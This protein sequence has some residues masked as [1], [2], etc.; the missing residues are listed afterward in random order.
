MKRTAIWAAVGWICGL[1][2][3]AGFGFWYGFAYGGPS[4]RLKPGLEA[5][6]T[7]AIDAPIFFWWV[8][9]PVGA[10]FGGATGC[11]SWFVRPRKS[12]KKSNREVA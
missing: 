3:L 12:G 2:A 11:G 5:A 6:M 1:L 10:L 9:G 7:S 4:S 8:G